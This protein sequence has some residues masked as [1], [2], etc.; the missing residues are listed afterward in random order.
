MR[1]SRLALITAIL[2]IAALLVACAPAPAAPAGGG[3]APAPAPAPP[4]PPAPPAAPGAPT[5]PAAAPGGDAGERPRPDDFYTRTHIVIGAA[6]PHSGRFQSFED[7]GFGVFYRNWVEEVNSRPEGGLWVEEYQ[8]YLPIHLIRYDDTS[9]MGTMLMLTDR[10]MFED[11]VDFILPTCSSAMMTAQAEVTNQN[12][13]LLFS[14]EGGASTIVDNWQDFPY[15]FVTNSHSAH[16]VPAMVNLFQEQGLRTLFMVYLNDQHG[17]EYFTAVNRHFPAAGLEVVNSVMI[18]PDIADMTPIIMDA[19]A[20][21]AD[22]FFLAGYAAQIYPAL[23]IMAALDYRP[24]LVLFTTAITTDQFPNAFPDNPNIVEGVM[25][26]G[27][28]VP[29]SSPATQ[30]F[31]DRFRAAFPGTIIDYW[32]HLYYEVIFE[33]FEQAIV[34]AGTLNNT[35]VARLM[36]SGYVFETIVGPVWY[37]QNSLAPEAYFGHIVQWQN[38]RPELVDPGPGRTADPIIPMPP[39]S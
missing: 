34:A 30:D 8:R 27:T 22:A 10:M 38:G 24:G 14:A 9:D 36:S 4:A 11:Q 3:A 12:G 13:F 20:S 25:G 1:K 39:W 5:P 23:E 21:G 19:M 7:T 29:H 15:F 35:E 28:W 32:T 17:M 37:V 31:Y 18:P 2:L 33:V 26:F 6:R 16:Q